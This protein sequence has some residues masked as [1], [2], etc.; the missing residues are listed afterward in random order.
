MNKKFYILAGLIGLLITTLSVS[1]ITSA[2]T[3]N[4]W[5]PFAKKDLDPEKAAEMQAHQQAV[6]QA[7]ANNNYDAWQELM[8]NQCANQASE[9]KF[10]AMQKRYQE[11]TAMQA[12][13]TSSDY[14]V[15]KQ[16]MADRGVAEE[17]LTQENFAKV[18]Q[19][20]QLTEEGKFQEAM[21]LQKEL[22]F[23]GGFGGRGFKGGM[24]RMGFHR[25]FDKGITAS[26]TEQ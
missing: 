3:G 18:Q 8:T 26:Q 7:L 5:G 10:Q 11:Q 1:A 13:I 21:Q 6:Q 9:E 25:G 20:Q 2:G 23:I 22:G 12:A 16:L 14:N 19:I 17:K 15:W 4:F 24:M